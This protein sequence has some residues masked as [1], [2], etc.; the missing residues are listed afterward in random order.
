MVKS[1][2]RSPLLSDNRP[3]S[4]RLARLVADAHSINEQVL[5]GSD[6][7]AVL[8]HKTRSV[9]VLID[10]SSEH[11]FGLRSVRQDGTWANGSLRHAES[12]TPV[13]W[14]QKL[15]A[16]TGWQRSRRRPR[17][18]GSS[19][20]LPRRAFAT[21]AI[22]TRADRRPS[23]LVPARLPDRAGCAVGPVSARTRLP[24]TD[25][26]T[27]GPRRFLCRSPSVSSR[28]SDAAFAEFEEQS[29]QMPAAEASRRNTLRVSPAPRRS[30][31]AQPVGVSAESPTA[32]PCARG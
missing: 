7:Q 24:R 23:R 2:I 30:R 22:V 1:S 17:R 26:P 20:G 11:A 6:P 21:A 5:I 10:S 8:S 3:C 25:G 16:R 4:A 28:K 15:V 14:R 32:R 18:S 9:R 27:A 29:Q 12:T 13:S 31:G 19:S